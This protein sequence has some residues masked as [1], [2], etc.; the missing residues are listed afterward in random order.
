MNAQFSHLACL[1]GESC[2]LQESQHPNETLCSASETIQRRHHNNAEDKHWVSD[3]RCLCA[4]HRFPQL[5]EPG[6]A[7]TAKFAEDETVP[8]PSRLARRFG[9]EARSRTAHILS[10][11]EA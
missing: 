4:P 6:L 5:R 7:E 9:N 1:L 2:M 10:D 8:P 3:L 11:G